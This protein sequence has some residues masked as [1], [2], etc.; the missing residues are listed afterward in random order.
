[1]AIALATTR[2]HH[3]FAAGRAL[4]THLLIGWDFRRM[5]TARW[6]PHT[7]PQALPLFYRRAKSILWSVLTDLMK[8]RAH[9]CQQTE[10]YLLGP[11]EIIM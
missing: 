8:P 11:S 7:L 4:A 2:N 1:M 10:R 9:Q 3:V 6:L 5:L